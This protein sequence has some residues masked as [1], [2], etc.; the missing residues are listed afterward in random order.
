[1]SEISQS[2]Y[3]H[4]AP[5]INAGL[6]SQILLPSEQGYEAR[7]AT[8]WSRAAALKPA[9]IVRPRSA[10][11]VSVAV[12][13]LVS[14][15]E[16][17]AVRSGGHAPSQGVSNIHGGVTIDLSLI[18]HIE[19]DD[20]S[21]T[22]K[23]GP[24]Q[25]WRQ[26]YKELQK[27]N[28][29][30]AGSRDGSVGVAGFLLGGGYS[31]ITTRKGWGCD[32]VLSFEVVLGDG[33]IITATADENQHADLF[34]ALKGGGNNF[35][36]VTSFTMRTIPCS[37]VWG[38]KVIAPN[39]AI[40]DV[41]R[42]CS[43]IPETISK[44]PDANVVMVIA[45]VPERDEIVASGALVQ[46]QGVADDP[47]M[48]ELMALPKIMDTT[49]I[50]TIYDLTF[51]FLLPHN[52]YNSW[53][54]I[55]VKNDERII[56]KAVDAHQNLVEELKSFATE[57][58]FRTQCILQPLPTFIAEHSAATGGNIMGIERHQ[59]NGVIFLL[60][61]MM[62][63]PEQEAFAHPR[64]KAGIEAV[65]EF[66]ATI[67]GGNL[68]WIYMNYADKTQD[69]LGGYGIDNV[70]RMKDVATKYD[71]HQV[72]QKLCPGGWKIVDVKL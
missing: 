14:A 10:E 7:E 16:K 65:K 40:P 25:R 35:G 57:A 21:E 61:A 5:L 51:E 70:R 33:R 59:S 32:N 42:I 52:Y 26:V 4:V 68:P 29:T 30:V 55:S 19:Y 43:S 49:K 56:A 48:Q 58:D 54:T 17:F 45:Y 60:S 12:K 11:E 69:V 50:S 13:A 22:A 47:G 8:Y 15:G 44:F 20:V 28:R 6:Q 72:F 1:M 23:I 53:F 46:T 27:H 2:L 37:H 41:V 66:A 24:G 71:P 39:E 38:G 9:C 62:K 64:V 67:E 63:T 36:V 18:D 31:W 34:R 3:P